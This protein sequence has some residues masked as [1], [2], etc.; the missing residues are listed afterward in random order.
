MCVGF[1][2]KSNPVTVCEIDTLLRDL[3]YVRSDESNI[4][5]ALENVQ[6]GFRSRDTAKK[7]I[8]IF[9]DGEN[10]DDEWDNPTSPIPKARVCKVTD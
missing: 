9:F 8:W 10:T 3:T 7:I 6:S 1:Q 2:S 4:I 5:K